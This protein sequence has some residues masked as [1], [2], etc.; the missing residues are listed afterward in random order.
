MVK[1]ASD[2][3][4]DVTGVGM[5]WWRKKWQPTPVLL[6]N[7]RHRSLVGYHPWGH[8]ASDMTEQLSTHAQANLYFLL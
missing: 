7:P 4:G 2:N 5:I 3:A 6:K 1:N 8:R